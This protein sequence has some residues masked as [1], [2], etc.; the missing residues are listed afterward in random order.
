MKLPQRKPH[1]AMSG[2]ELLDKVAKT[3]KPKLNEL[4]KAMGD[5][6]KTNGDDTATK[7]S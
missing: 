1:T 5:S 7:G 4:G 6:I 2:R 3:Q